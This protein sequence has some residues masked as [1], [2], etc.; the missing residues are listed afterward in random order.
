VAGTRSSTA[1]S[2]DERNRP[3]IAYEIS[4]SCEE[5]LL[6]AD[7]VVHALAQVG[8]TDGVRR[9]RVPV[10]H[11]ELVLTPAMFGPPDSLSSV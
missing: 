3:L 11:T 1:H 6:V 8:S 10:V 2:T 7:D 9:I 4:V 5:P